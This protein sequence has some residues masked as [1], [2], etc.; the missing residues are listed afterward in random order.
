MARRRG[1]E[2]GSRG[3]PTVGS[4]YLA[5]LGEFTGALMIR[6]VILRVCRSVT[7][8]Q[9]PVA[10]SCV[11]YDCQCKPL[12][13][14]LT[15][16]HILMTVRFILSVYNRRRQV[17]LYVSWSIWVYK[18]TVHEP[19]S[20]IANSYE[21]EVLKGCRSIRYFVSLPRIRISVPGL[22]YSFWAGAISM[23]SVCDLSTS[24]CLKQSLW[25]LVCISWHL[26]PS[27]RLTS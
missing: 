27:Q 24:E 2:H 5:T 18:L 8:L 3:I 14:S 11:K 12:V 16:D 13:Q 9:P 25:N 1:R 20:N 4:R 17:I 15:R 22:P 26:S 6:I 7:E 10:T 23:L 21:T 19:D